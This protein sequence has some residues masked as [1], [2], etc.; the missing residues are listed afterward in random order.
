MLSMG[1]V[2]GT[3]LGAASDGRLQPVEAR[4]VPLGKSLDHCMELAAKHAEQDPLKVSF[5]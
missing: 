4:P 1:Y 5:H 2:P 3:G